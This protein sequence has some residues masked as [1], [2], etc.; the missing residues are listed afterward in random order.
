M[1][2]FIFFFIYS[3]NNILIIVLVILVIVPD[4]F[5]IYDKLLSS[6]DND[7]IIESDNSDKKTFS[8][9]NKTNFK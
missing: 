6:N 5:I 1:L 3:L 7:G 8:K 9:I 2:T 4:C